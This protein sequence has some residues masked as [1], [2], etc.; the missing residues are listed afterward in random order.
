MQLIPGV[1]NIQRGEELAES[2]LA[3]PVQ[4]D[5]EQLKGCTNYSQMGRDTTKLSMDVA[6]L[7]VFKLAGTE[8]GRK[9]DSILI[10]LKFIFKFI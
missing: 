2:T 6:E 4:L 8:R 10:Y 3:S 7:L 5:S 9:G 1:R